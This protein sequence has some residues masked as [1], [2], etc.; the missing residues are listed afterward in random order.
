MRMR[1]Y[2]TVANEF[3]EELAERGGNALPA[4]FDELLTTRVFKSGRE[5]GLTVDD[6]VRSMICGQI[7]ICDEFL[8]LL[9]AAWEAREAKASAEREDQFRKG[10]GGD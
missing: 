5:V 10:G 4:L 6:G 8:R 9:K 2:E 7:S 1:D 3:F